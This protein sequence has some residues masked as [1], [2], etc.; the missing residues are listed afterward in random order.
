LDGG[1]CAGIWRR[2]RHLRAG[3]WDDQDHRRH[4]L[5]A[6]VS[7][8]ITILVALPLNSHAQV[9]RHVRL[10]IP[11]RGNDRGKAMRAAIW[12]IALV[13]GLAVPGG[14][15]ADD[16]LR[17]FTD[18]LNALAKQAG[19][20]KGNLIV[21]GGF[22]E[23]V[24]RQGAYVTYQPG[25]S[26]TGW[27]VIGPS[28]GVSPISGGYTHSGIRFVAREGK[29]WLDLTGPSASTGV[30]VQQTVQVTPGQLYDLAFWVGNVSAGGFGN[31]STVEVF[32]DG[33]S[34]GLARNDQ[35]MPGQQGWGRFDMQVTA[36]GSTMTLA[37]VNRDPSNDNS[38]GL[39]AVSLVPAKV[40]QTQATTSAAAAAPSPAAAPTPE[41]APSPAAATAAAALS[42]VETSA[43]FLAAGFKQRGNEWR[44][45]CGEEAGSA[46][47]GAGSIDQVAD[48]NGDGRPEVVIIE[49]GTYCYGRTGQGY[50]LL[51]QQSDAR[52]KVMDS[53]T[54]MLQ[55]LNTK[56]RDGWPDLGIAGPG[57]CFPVLRW[58]GR[59][60]AQQRWEYDGKACT[61]PY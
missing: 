4:L 57:L 49:G 58:N 16:K 19:G 45:A 36:T 1:G 13:F 29:Q 2:D 38:N 3:R 5:L 15:T 41:T 33:Q 22:E 59:E 31:V 14:V 60:Y 25:Q 27:Q 40:A 56:G 46:S 37:F 17:K 30:G 43:A 28:G 54:G 11:S 61:P 50:W 53:G 47:D 8:A 51:S 42:A 39:D 35:F 24:V 44:S 23:P 32:V 26:F 7:L 34:L 9:D 48:L 55:V 21:N 10:G 18:V 52:W 6:G 20:P 12:A